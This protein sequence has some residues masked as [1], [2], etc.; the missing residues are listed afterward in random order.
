[1]S[2]SNQ[3]ISPKKVFI[4]NAHAPWPYSKGELNRTF[5]EIAKKYFQDLGAEVKETH[6]TE[7]YDIS[8]EKAKHTWA[9]LV[10]IQSPTFWMGTPWQ[11]KKYMDE[12]YTAGM[13]GSLCKGDGRHE[14]T[15]QD[16]YGTGGSLGNTH[17]MLSLT[18]NAPEGAFGREDQFL[19]QGKSVDDLWFP[20]HMNARFFD[21]KMIPTFSIHDVIK[22]PKIEE[23]KKN[24]EEHLKKYFVKS[25]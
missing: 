18:F 24:Y 21:M 8:E 15:P 7:T 9:D 17:Y 6:V 2:A 1:M 19:F 4:I 16:G 3:T 22:N 14:E 25:G 23:G 10:I 20:F 12:V 11:M 13:D 5:A